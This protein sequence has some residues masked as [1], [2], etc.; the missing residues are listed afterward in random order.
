MKAE[1]KTTLIQGRDLE[2]ELLERLG[3]QY[4][5]LLDETP[6]NFP[7]I[8]KIAAQDCFISNRQG[9]DV[10]ALRGAL[11]NIQRGVFR[12]DMEYIGDLQRALDA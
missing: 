3:P 9:P 4:I 8:L 12:L 1:I 11:G 6:V 5:Q 2:R 10:D 7:D